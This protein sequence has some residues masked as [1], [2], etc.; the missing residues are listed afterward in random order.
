MLAY[1]LWHPRHPT[2]DRLIPPHSRRLIVI[3]DL[4]GLGLSVKVGDGLSVELVRMLAQG[5]HPAAF[6]LH[7]EEYLPNLRN[8]FR[9]CSPTA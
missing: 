8:R 9:H 3:L 6:A 2:H 7:L 1:S 4:D 5:G